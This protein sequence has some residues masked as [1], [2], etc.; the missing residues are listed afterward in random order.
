MINTLDKP[1]VQLVNSY[2]TIL[3]SSAG[4]L[5]GTVVA[6]AASP[7]LPVS[8]SQN[9]NETFHLHHVFYSWRVDG[10]IREGTSDVPLVFYRPLRVSH[11]LVGVSE[12]V[13]IASRLRITV[14]L[15]KIQYQELA[16]FG[17]VL[18]LLWVPPINIVQLNID[19]KAHN[20]L[21]NYKYS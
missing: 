13:C 3:S 7:S 10:G 14:P 21:F 18:Y 20:F 11:E 19:R 6:A 15:P 5:A 16:L 2:H 12:S 8:S 17:T 9:Q 4:H 1:L